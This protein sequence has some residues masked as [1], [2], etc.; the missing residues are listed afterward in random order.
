[1]SAIPP[2]SMRVC[3]RV[4]GVRRCAAT[5]GYRMRSLRDQSATIP[6]G[7]TCNDPNGI[8]AHRSQ[9][10]PSA[11]IP[12]G[13]SHTDRDAVTYG[14]RGFERSEHPRTPN[15]RYPPTATRSHTCLRSLRDRYAFVR[16]FRGCAAARRP[17]ATVCDPSGINLQRS[18]WDPRASIPTGSSRIDP[19]GILAHRSQRYSPTPTATRSHM[20]AGGLSVA[21]TPGP[22]TCAT[23]RPLRGRIHFCDP[24]GINLQRSK[25]DRPPTDSNGGPYPLQSTMF[26]SI[27]TLPFLPCLLG[28]CHVDFSLH[29]FP[30]YFFYQTSKA[31]DRRQMDWRPAW[32]SWWYRQRSGRC[33][34]KDRWR[35][36]SCTHAD[37]L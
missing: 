28:N 7:S 3:A 21:N 12:T 24:S 30:Y 15:V 11:S 31:L 6:T 37:R 25:R 2:G 4:P 32:I 10:D 33:P 35:G 23:H 5:P 19:D 22:R 14:S 29:P 20:V 9:W 27:E 18:Q 1:M 8:F 36:R 16:A 34:F 13:F 17:P 26:Q